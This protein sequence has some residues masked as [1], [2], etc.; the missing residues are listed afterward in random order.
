MKRNL[1]AGAA[2]LLLTGCANFGGIDWKEELASTHWRGLD[3]EPSSATAFTVYQGK[4][5]TNTRL[6]KSGLAKMESE[7]C[8]GCHDD[9]G[10][11]P[12][13]TVALRS[14]EDSFAGSGLALVKK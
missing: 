13:F 9:G 2:I 3:Q 8:V 11:K 5:V 10:V 7:G 6:N 1:I 4:L 12:S 14:K